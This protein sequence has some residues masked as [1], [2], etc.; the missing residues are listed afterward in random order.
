MSFSIRCLFLGHYDLIV[1]GPERLWLQCNHCGRET[2]GW[3]LA[4]SI[5]SHRDRLLQTSLP[6]AQ[7]ISPLHEFDHRIAA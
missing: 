6:D 5:S 2:R 3:N 4:S 7:P 1:R